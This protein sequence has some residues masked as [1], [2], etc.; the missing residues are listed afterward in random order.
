MIDPEMLEYLIIGGGPAGLQMAYFLNEAGRSYVVL[1]ADDQVGSF[2]RRFP[3]HGKLLSINKR[4]TGRKDAEFNLRHDWNSLLSDREELRLSGFSSD[5]FPSAKDLVKYLDHFSS[6]CQ[7]N[8]ELRK[9]VTRVER[10]PDGGF[11]IATS[12][13]TEYRALRVLVATGIALPNVPNIPGIELA[14]GYESMSTDP[15]DFENQSV[16]I[17]GKGN[18]A[19]ETADHLIPS[20]SLIHVLSPTPLKLAWQS[21]FVGHLRAVN[22]NLLDTYRLKSQNAAID[23]VVHAITPA[24]G[25]GLRVKFASIHVANET[26]QLDYDRVLRCTG[27]RFDTSPFAESCR[28]QLRA[29]GRLPLMTSGF[30]AEGVE[31]MFFLGAPTQALDYKRAQ[32]AFIHGFRYNVRS[33]FHLLEQRYHGVPLPGDQLPNEPEA[34]ARSVLARMNRTSSLWQQVGFLADLLVFPS[35][36]SGRVEYLHDLPYDY[37]REHAE[38]LTAGR[39]YCIGMFHLGHCPS[40]PFDHP[41][42]ADLDN[43]ESSGTIHPFFE[44]YRN[45]QRLNQFHVLEDFLGDWSGREYVDSLS[46]FFAETLGRPARMTNRESEVRHIVRDRSMRLVDGR[47][48]ASS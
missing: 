17:L 38:Q 45:G 27:F 2:F 33:L 48:V 37:L 39:D 43:G 26:E 30:Q 36:P 23:A 32:S 10:A 28:P 12:D 16:L 15:S 3:R 47:K 20:A 21:R 29:C 19:F 5:Y 6:T 40:D 11:R 44:S 1:E 4:F 34:I 24:P 18:S 13:G 14:E 35:E 7:L 22:N 9:R 41:R 42:S 31:D 8:V 25:G 46:N